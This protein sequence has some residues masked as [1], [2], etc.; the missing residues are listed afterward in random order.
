CESGCSW[1]GLGLDPKL[2]GHGLGHTDG[3][4]PHWIKVRRYNMELLLRIVKRLEVVPEGKGTMMDNTLIVYTSCHAE[5]QHSNGSRWA[6]MLLGN[7]G[8]R[9]RSGRYIQYPIAEVGRGQKAARS[10]NALYTTLLHAA[11]A[12]RD[13]F[14]LTGQLKDIDKPGPLSE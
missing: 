10:I 11:G 2:W 3:K 13:Q 5:Q 6:Y 8:G 14:N 7:A 1:A 9:I 4:E 12:P